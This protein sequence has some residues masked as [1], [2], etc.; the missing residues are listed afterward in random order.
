MIYI[1]FF[2]VDTMGRGRGKSKHE[3]TNENTPTPSSGVGKKRMSIESKY[4]L[5]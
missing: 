5:E 1:Q 4:P 2:N 3:E